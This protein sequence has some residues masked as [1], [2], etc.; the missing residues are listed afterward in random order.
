MDIS[1]FLS[2]ALGLY[3]VII[4]VGMLINAHTLKPILGEMLK[5]PALM[6]VTGMIAIIIGALIVISH[7][8]WILDWRVIITI[9]GWA[10]LIKG[11]IRVVIP[12]YV[13][14]LD[15]K[16]MLSDASYYT[17]FVLAFLLGVVLCYLGAVQDTLL[18]LS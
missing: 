9:M 7:N 8:I 11:T 12:Q 15:K 17:T 3:L 1:L 6:F 2:K 14:V 4:S 5:S 13:N 10:S 16:W 18:H